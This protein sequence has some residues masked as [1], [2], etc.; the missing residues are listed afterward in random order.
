MKSVNVKNRIFDDH[1]YLIIFQ[2][3]DPRK[4][5]KNAKRRKQRLLTS[6]IKTRQGYCLPTSTM[7]RN[8]GMNVPGKIVLPFANHFQR[9]VRENKIVNHKL[10]V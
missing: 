9:V 7:K 3:S 1:V 6:K 10:V 8:A 5:G 4:T 2:G